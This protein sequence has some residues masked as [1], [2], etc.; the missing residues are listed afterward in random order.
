MYIHKYAYIHTHTHIYKYIYVLGHVLVSYRQCH[1]I[2]YPP[3]LF[4]PAG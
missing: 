2:T 4:G 1:E 3:I